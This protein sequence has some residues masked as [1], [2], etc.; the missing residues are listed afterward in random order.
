[1]PA[2]IDFILNHIDYVSFPEGIRTYDLTCVAKVELCT[3]CKGVIFD[4]LVPPGRSVSQPVITDA[5]G[6]RVR[7]RS[8][9]S[10]SIQTIDCVG[11]IDGYHRKPDVFVLVVKCLCFSVVPG[12]NAPSHPCHIIQC[13][14]SHARKC[15]SWTFSTTTVKL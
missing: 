15:F 4:L 10:S 9:T 6:H 2:L 1:M 7:S 3:L 12:L 8:L 11:K 13:L 5:E 14:Y